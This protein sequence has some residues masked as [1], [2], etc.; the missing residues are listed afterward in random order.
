MKALGEFP[1]FAGIEKEVLY[2]LQKSCVFNNFSRS[3]N[4]NIVHQDEPC[5]GLWILF[6]GSARKVKNTENGTEI[7]FGTITPNEHFGEECIGSKWPY[8][9]FT[10]TSALCLYMP[11]SVVIKAIGIPQVAERLMMSMARKTAAHIA[12]IQE[13][14]E[15]SAQE[16]AR[17]EL[18]RRIES[19]ERFTHDDIACT[20]ATVRETV[21]RVASAM[22]RA[23]IIE[24]MGPKKSRTATYRIISDAVDVSTLRLYPT[25][26][27]YSEYR[28]FRIA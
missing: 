3:E 6:G 26:R 20:V 27:N 19:G 13:M 23:K 25:A 5:R 12:R 7:H 14:A 22:M 16:R 17:R 4:P 15:Y 28:S 8:D 21:A 1:L 24:K 10:E 2:N 11:K 9:I 18:L